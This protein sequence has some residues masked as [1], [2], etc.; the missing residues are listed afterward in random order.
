M[1]NGYRRAS[2]PAVHLI[3]AMKG[4][5]LHF[6]DEETGWSRAIYLLKMTISVKNGTNIVPYGLS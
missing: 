4:L 6:R 1:L 2:S 3:S 5:S